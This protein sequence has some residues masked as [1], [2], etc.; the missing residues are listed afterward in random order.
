M[1]FLPFPKEKHDRKPS[2][3]RSEYA[4]LLSLLGPDASLPSRETCFSRRP[5]ALMP[6]HSGLLSP[7]ALYYTQILK[8]RKRKFSK[9]L[10][11]A[12]GMGALNSLRGSI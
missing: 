11:S 5:L 3:V 10:K 2:C 12:P 6:P 7:R 4:C 1:F 9:R 8:K